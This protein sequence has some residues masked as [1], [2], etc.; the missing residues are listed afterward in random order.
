MKLGVIFS[1]GGSA[2]FGAYSILFG[3][4]K[5]KANE[6][7]IITDRQCGAEKTAIEYGI[8]CKRISDTS[9]EAFSQS[10]ASELTA[11]G[12]DLVLLYFSRLVT[13]KLHE[14]LSCMNIH[15]SILPAFPGFGA[16]AQAQEGAVRMVGATLHR[17][18]EAVDG[19]PIVAQVVSP[20][21][22]GMELATLQRISFVQK[23]YLTL[24]AVDLA[25]SGLMLNDLSRPARALRVTPSASPALQ[26]ADLIERFAAVLAGRPETIMIP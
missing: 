18:T 20:V 19:G 13:P 23:V 7:S 17:V 12:C 22:P 1:S 2:F 4:G 8:E 21:S 9:N 15:P 3:A 11:A 25:E 10:A 5:L 6:V 26:S 16:L 14:D 24:V